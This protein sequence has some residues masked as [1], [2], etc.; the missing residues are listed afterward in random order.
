MRPCAEMQGQRSTSQEST[1]AFAVCLL[2][3]QLRIFSFSGRS[4][5]RRQLNPQQP[6]VGEGAYRL[7][8]RGAGVPTVGAG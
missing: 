5:E 4:L 7:P 6:T 8:V 2:V 3:D 1:E